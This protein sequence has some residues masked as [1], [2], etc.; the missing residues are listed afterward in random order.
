MTQIEDPA[1]TRHPGGPMVD[2]TPD[3]R[4][5][6]QQQTLGTPPRSYGVDARAIFW[7]EDRVW[8]TGRTLSKFKAR[9]LVARSPY[10]AWA[11]VHPDSTSDEEEKRNE[12]SHWHVL[13]ELIAE[14]NCHDN[15]VRFG[16]LPAMGAAAMYVFTRVQ[17]RLD[18]ARS[19]RL[20]AD[21]EDHAEHE[22]ALLVAEH[23]EWETRPYTAAV[24]EYGE[25]E[26]RA[27]VLRQISCDERV[28]KERSQADLA[29]GST[30]RVTAGRSEPRRAPTSRRTL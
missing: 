26:S 6:H 2:L 11:G 24:P 27:D 1:R 21:I 8:G 18:E 5:D 28:H 4:R 23:P 19:H 12:I 20:N 22:Y 30:T 16:L 15:P 29:S 7:L 14:D 17:H 10:A 9:E 25:Y 3:E 13:R